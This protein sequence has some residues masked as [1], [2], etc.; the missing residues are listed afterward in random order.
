MRAGSRASGEAS[1]GSRAVAQMMESSSGVRV[2]LQNGSALIAHAGA[3]APAGRR[4]MLSGS[5]ST[6]TRRDVCTALVCWGLH[7]W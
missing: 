1:D 6:S 3:A 2:T 7:S 4:Q 5:G